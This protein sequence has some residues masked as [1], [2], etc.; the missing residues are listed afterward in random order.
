MP[1]DF[2]V[3]LATAADVPAI[4]PM[5]V[6]FNRFEEIAWSVEKGEPALRTLLGDSAL[7]VVGLV[8]RVEGGAPGEV[9]PRA[10]GYFVLTWGFDLEWNGRDAFLTELYLRPEERGARRGDLVLVEAERVARTHGANALHLMVRHENAPAR[11]LYDRA[12]YHEPKRAFLSK[13]LA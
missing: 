7:G 6:D 3:R 2:D 12:G 5:M 11:R 9:R 1:R 13:V 4:L 10:V 8:E